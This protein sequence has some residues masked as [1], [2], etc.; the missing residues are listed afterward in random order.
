MGSNY[1]KINLDGTIEPSKQYIE[2]MEARKAE[3]KAKIEQR[4][5]IKNNK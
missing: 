5:Q 2:E 3:W 4:K 1:L